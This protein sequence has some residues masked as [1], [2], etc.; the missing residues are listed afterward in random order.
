[1]E[2]P[3]PG[4]DP[5]I[6]QWREVSH[7][8]GWMDNGKELR[9]PVTPYV[10]TGDIREYILD[11]KNNWQHWNIPLE[12]LQTRSTLEQSNKKLGGGVEQTFY[13]SRLEHT[14]KKGTFVAWLGREVLYLEN[15]KSP[16]NH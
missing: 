14:D 6:N 4:F 7:L 11:A 16:V 12:N 1:K 8:P 5:T 10:C 9:N 2:E 13:A 15:M 3:L